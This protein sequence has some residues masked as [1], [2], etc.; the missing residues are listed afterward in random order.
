M[1]SLYILVLGI[2]L[3]LSSM[4]EFLFP[5]HAFRF[6]TWYMSGKKFFLH[7]AVLIS[8][9]LPLVMYRGPLSTVI[10]IIGALVILTGPFVLIYPEKI[11]GM[12]L[13]VSSELDGRGIRNLVFFDA[14]V[15]G[16]AG[17]LFTVSYFIA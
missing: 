13:S 15:R 16:M 17:M 4:A 12:Y 3:L 10:F 8:G 9:G 7:G 14:T 6:W 5:L 2:T 1:I 11:R